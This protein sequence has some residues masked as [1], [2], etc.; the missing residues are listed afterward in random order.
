MGRK[1]PIHIFNIYESWA[2]L[3]E[4]TLN[5]VL[6]KKIVGIVKAKRNNKLVNKTLKAS[7]SDFFFIVWCSCELD[8]K[9]SLNHG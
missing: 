7:D 1:Y 6:G 3:L 4:D 8:S 5:G 9:L 2:L